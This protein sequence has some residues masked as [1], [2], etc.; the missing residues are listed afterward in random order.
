[1]RV[2]RWERHWHAEGQP[3]R[4]PADYPPVSVATSGTHDTEPLA[5][6]WERASEDERRKVSAIGTVQRLT[7]GTGI[8]HAGLDEVRDV[9][10]ETLYASGSDL[11]LLP[12]QDVFGWRDRINQPATVGDGNWT[13]R[14]PWPADRLT[15]EPEAMDVANQLQEWSRKHGRY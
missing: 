15:T 11:L 3:F 10:L 2:L 4:E 14:L 9:L 6:W 7:N 13:W 8:A 1:M 5:S 12:I